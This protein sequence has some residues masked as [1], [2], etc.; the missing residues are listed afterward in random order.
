MENIFEGILNAV[1]L[2]IV[3]VDTTH[4]ITFMNKASIEKYKDK[5]GVSLV[6]K[7]IFACHNKKSKMLILEGFKKLQSGLDKMLV[8]ENEEIKEY[9]LA[10]RDNSIL[11]G[12]SEIIEKK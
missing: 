3:F 9:M 10:V 11:L 7:S 2:P 5:G 4:T 12:Y 1:E 8:F 6:G